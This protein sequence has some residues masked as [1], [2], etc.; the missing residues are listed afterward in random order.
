M[1]RLLLKRLV[2]SA[3][4]AACSLA[5]LEGLL[6]LGSLTVGPRGGGPRDDAA[7]E[8]ILCVGDSHTYGIYCSQ[9]EAYPGRLESRLRERAPGRYR[10]VNLGLPGMNS[11]QIRRRLPLWL[12]RYRP[13]IVVFCAGM[14]NVWNTSDT[15]NAASDQA[16]ISLLRGLR[17]YRLY[18]LTVSAFR[19]GRR[20]E[21]PA[22]RPALKRVVLP[23]GE[24]AVEQHDARTGRELI[25]HRGNPAVRKPASEAAAL[26]VRDLGEILRLTR[27]RG[28]GLLLLSYSATPTEERPGWFV[29]PVMLGDAM[30][31]FGEE[32]QVEMVDVRDR[33]RRLLD[34]GARRTDYF[35]G[36]RDDHPNP[37]G[38]A[39]IAAMVAEAVLRPAEDQSA[40]KG[41]D[42]L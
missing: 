13:S 26:L 15:E 24:G 12:D 16:P 28:V 35:A 40:D 1:K 42:G 33:F 8:T 38:Y 34:G 14:N 23:E 4:A 29:L 10:V 3:A 36:E 5:A 18:R 20:E 41:E 30:R 31:R 21:E 2:L 22:V 32:N 27:R 7:R 37:R 19:E 11:S 25:R 6:W 9:E 39:Q 17:L